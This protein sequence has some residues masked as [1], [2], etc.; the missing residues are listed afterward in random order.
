KESDAHIINIE[1]PIY[2]ENRETGF[3]EVV[4]S[5]C[6]IVFSGPYPSDK[7]TVRI[8]LP[9]I[10]NTVIVNNWTIPNKPI[11][12]S[13]LLEKLYILIENVNYPIKIRDFYY[14]VSDPRH[15]GRK[16]TLRHSG[17]QDFSIGDKV[18]A[19]Y[20]FESAD[21]SCLSFA[22]DE[23]LIIETVDTDGWF[24]AK[25]QNDHKTCDKLKPRSPLFRIKFMKTAVGIIL[26]F[27]CANI[28]GQ[29]TSITTIT[30]VTN[31]VTVFTTKTFISGITSTPTASSNSSAP[32]SDSASQTS[33]TSP[34]TDP[35]ANGA[36][37]VN[38][39]TP[40]IPIIIG[41]SLGALVLI[42]ILIMCIKRRRNRVKGNN[43]DGN[44]FEYFDFSAIHH[45][46]EPKEPRPMS[47]AIQPSMYRESKFLPD[48]ESN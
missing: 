29:T 39:T 24:T 22:K 10:D 44:I 9:K 19:L 6:D 8:S 18:K 21:T 38:N 34:S 14:H 27:L 13:R 32:T 16:L 45:K 36:S 11:S 47:A 25:N 30:N 40:L 4:H 41:A 26:G 46:N 43:Y 35:H 5:A 42:G 33:T 1:L 12:L 23:V 28:F 17:F 48:I 37:S 31:G 7:Y 20:S 15:W 2:F 3:H